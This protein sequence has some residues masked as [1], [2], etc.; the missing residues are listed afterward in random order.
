MSKTLDVE[1]SKLMAHHPFGI[2]LYRPL[3]S[4][5]FKLGACGY[6]EFGHWNPICDLEV[7]NSL[8]IKDSTS[9]KTIEKAPLDQ[10]L[11]ERDQSFLKSWHVGTHPRIFFHD[12]ELLTV[13]PHLVSLSL[14]PVSTSIRTIKTKVPFFKLHQRWTLSQNAIDKLGEKKCY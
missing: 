6:F 7:S 11:N 10:G 4:D 5:S 14:C 1:Y 13:I 2:A 12:S 9:L 8:D 3:P